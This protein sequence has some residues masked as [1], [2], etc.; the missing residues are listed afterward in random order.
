MNKFLYDNNKDN[1]LIVLNQRIRLEDHEVIAKYLANLSEFKR[2]PALKLLKLRDLISGERVIDLLFHLPNYY[3]TREQ[4]SHLSPDLVGNNIAIKPI[5]TSHERAFKRG[6]PH[7]VT[8]R[9][10][11]GQII[12]L[13]FFNFNFPYLKKL[14]PENSSKIILG[15]LTNYKNSYRISNPDYIL[16]DKEFAD[17]KVEPIYPLTAGINNR[18]IISLVEYYLAE[19]DEAL[20]WLDP[21]LVKREKLPSFLESL[22]KIHQPQTEQEIL[23]VERYKKRLAYDELLA[24]QFSLKKM[25][26]KSGNKQGNQYDFNLDLVNKLKAK[27]PFTLTSCQEQAVQAITEIQQGSEKLYALLQGDVGSGKTLVALLIMLNMVAAKKQAVLMAPTSLLAEQHY[28]ALKE[29]TDGLGINI[30]ILT[31]SLKA[32]EK[33]ERKKLIKNHWAQ[34]IIGTHALFYESVAFA[35]LGLAVI[36]E[37]HRFGVKQRERLLEK[38]DNCDLLLMSATPIP[39]TLAQTLYGDMQV[40]S[41]QNKPKNRKPIIT[42][43]SS[44]QKLTQIL[45]SLKKALAGSEKAYWICPLVSES[46]LIDLAACEDR[47]KEFQKFFGADKVG[48]IHG[49]MNEAEK[50]EVMQSFLQNKIKLLIATTVIEVGINVTD[51]TIIIIEQAERFGLAQLHQL[52]G[53]VGRGELQSKCLLIYDSEKISQFAKKRLNAIRDSEDGFYLA[54]EDLKIRGSGDIIGVKQSG[55]PDFKFADIARD[56]AYLKAVQKEVD[57][58]FLQETEKSKQRIEKLET[59]SALFNYSVIYKA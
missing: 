6:F 20:E 48:M 17:I 27:L 19:M 53:R 32:S 51:A 13:N 15:K 37:Q 41:L 22:Q 2:I 3:L 47:Y 45:A 52:R 39:R 50:D 35:D 18:F 11:S 36:D 21:E 1:S 49:K 30:T 46:E 56:L 33:K 16:N 24:H 59:L 25:R 38:G 42:S 5:I 4:I 57:Y 31:G 7:K 43:V 23:E 58:L 10:N 28:I 14:L 55:L 44:D 54:E 12:T 34:I 40:I 26:L 29:L 9:L 8:A